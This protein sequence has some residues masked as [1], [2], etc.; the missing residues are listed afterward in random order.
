VLFQTSRMASSYH[1][2]SSLWMAHTLLSNK[3][4]YS[5][6]SKS[7]S[8]NVWWPGNNNLNELVQALKTQFRGVVI[9]KQEQARWLSRRFLWFVI[10]GI[11]KR[12]QRSSFW[13]I[14]VVLSFF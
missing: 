11:L 4:G 5:C 13:Y 14:I 7:T 6:K 8:T 1:I 12:N 2:I 3:H 10:M 9:K